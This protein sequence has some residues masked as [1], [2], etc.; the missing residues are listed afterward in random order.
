MATSRATC[1]RRSV[2]ERQ[3]V[4]HDGD[5]AVPE[6]LVAV[7]ALERLHRSEVAAVHPEDRL[8]LLDGG[9]RVVQLLLV[10]ARALREDPHLLPRIRG[11]RDLPLVDAVQLGEAIELRV[12]PLE[13][14][15]RLDVPVVEAEHRAVRL[16]RRLVVADLVLVERGDLELERDP[17]RVAAAARSR[18]REQ[19]PG[20]V[21][22][23]LL[24][25]VDRRRAPRA[26]SR[27][28]RRARGRAGARRPP[29]PRHR[30]SPS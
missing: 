11:E 3:V 23:A 29:R 21:R 15:E 25:P 7:E 30:S 28:R 17:L 6:P 26:R 18:A 9:A 2:H 12:E 19:H 27:R 20:E 16:D 4:L 10:D 1:S 13:A 22:P 8:L 24:A 5:E 14:G